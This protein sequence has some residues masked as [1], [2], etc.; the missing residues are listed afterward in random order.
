MQR[1]LR[2]S[3]DFRN[4]TRNAR[5]LEV[6]ST[7]GDS[8]PGGACRPEPVDTLGF[9]AIALLA[10]GLWLP[11]L[12]GPIDLRWDGAAY[13]T[14]GSAL[15]SGRGYRLLNEPGDIVADQYPP[16]FSWWIALHQWALGSE[17]PFEVGRWLRVSACLVFVAYGCAI[18][19]LLRR[20]VP[21]RYAL[22]GAAICLLNL[23][24][25]FMSD[26]CFPEIPYALCTIGFFLAHDRRSPRLD[27]APAVVVA[28]AAFLLRSVGVALF[29]AWIAESALDRRFRVVGARLAASLLP[30]L[31]WQLHVAKVENSLEYREPAYAY[32]RADYLFYNVSYARNVFRLKDGFQPELGRLTWGSLRDRVVANASKVPTSLGESISSKERIWTVEWK[33]IRHR[34][35]A[36]WLPESVPRWIVLSIGMFVAAG[37]V[38]QL[39]QKQWLAPLYVLAWIGLACL[40]PWPG[41]FARYAVPLAPLL[42]LAIVEVLCLWKRRW[43]GARGVAAALFSLILV[44]QAAT[45]VVAYTKWRE[46]VEI[47]GR[48]GE[49]ESF[50]LFFYHDAYRAL[51][52]ALDRLRIEAAPSDVIAVSMPHWAYLRTG[53]KSVM[54]PLENDPAVAQRLLDSVPVRYLFVDLGLAA[55]LWHYT[56]SVV[57]AYPDR[58][59]RVYSSRVRDEIGEWEAREFQV[60][61]RT[62]VGRPVSVTD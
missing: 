18:Y 44:Q 5:P 45:A 26:L 9:A 55:D 15:A 16:L 43:R 33:E 10:F 30:I 37:F 14:L 4:V 39:A 59:Q 19:A 2:L 12:H 7:A 62:D 13:Y 24:T 48:H 17:D 22:P 60:F 46:A 11:R 27:A 40:T 41:Q 52:E 50:R 53:L 49:P 57:A 3:A 32:Q 34:L 28:F 61:R 38:A 29:V 54:P 51:D 23:H 47:R 42:S 21:R 56:S 25:Y 31:A 8:A 1:V 35:A 58:W 6:I 36:E 20:S